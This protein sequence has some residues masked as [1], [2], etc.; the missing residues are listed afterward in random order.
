MLVLARRAAEQ[1]GIAEGGYRL[2]MN[3]GRDSGNSVGHLHLHL[4]GGRT[5][6]GLG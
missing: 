1:A 3:V 5:L 6:G 2:V 4:L